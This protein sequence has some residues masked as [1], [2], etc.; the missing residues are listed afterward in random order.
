MFV[1]IT[2]DGVRK[3]I[4][5]NGTVSILDWDASG[6]KVKGKSE[7]AREINDHITIV[8]NKLLK[9]YDKLELR[10]EFINTDTLK[11]EYVGKRVERKK[12]LEIFTFKLERIAE[13]VGIKKTAQSTYNK[14]E[15]TFDHLT[16]FLKLTYEVDDVSFK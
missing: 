1:R 10:G 12:I 4:S 9:C 13:E 6:Q 2:I 5:A 3:E 14:Y 16:K 8:K 7:Q 15:G 11:N